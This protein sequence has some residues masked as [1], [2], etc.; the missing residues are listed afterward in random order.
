LKIDIDDA[1]REELREYARSH[2]PPDE[3]QASERA[4]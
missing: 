2:F 3:P 4:S 1:Q